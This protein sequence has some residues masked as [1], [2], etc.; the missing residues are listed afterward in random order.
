MK[1]LKAQRYIIGVTGPFGSGKSTAASFFESQGYKK[2]YLSFYLEQEAEK[3]GL[4]ITRKV[5]QDI[6][7][8]LREKFGNGYLMKKALSSLKD[9]KKVVIDGIRNLGEI[10]EIRKYKNSL[11]VAIIA[12]RDVRLKRLKKLKRREKLTKDLFDSLDSR[13]LGVGEKMTGLQGAFCLALADVFID[14]N[15][16]L[17]AFNSKLKKF[18]KEYET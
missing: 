2:I 13:D 16:D 8:E 11:V 10:E 3:R 9:E 18:L 6:G 17:K 5:L 4:K 7:N 12:N 14:S 15:G 1:S